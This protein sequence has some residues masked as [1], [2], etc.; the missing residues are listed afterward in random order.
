MSGRSTCQA[1]QSIREQGKTDRDALEIANNFSP[2]GILGRAGA[3]NKSDN[4]IINFLKNSITNTTRL[5]I[6]GKCKNATNS[7]QSNVY[8]GSDKC[9]IAMYQNCKNPITGITDL[10]CLDKVTK[11]L[12]DLRKSNVKVE[13]TNINT[14]RNLC[15][16]NSFIQAISSQ[17]TSL[18]NVAKLLSMQ[19][20]K[21]FLTNN[22]ADNLNCND[23]DVNVTNEQFISSVLNCLS[24]TSINQNNTIN[25][26][27][28]GARMS[29]QLNSN[30][31]FNN[32]LIDSG[33][34]VQNLQKASVVNDS[35]IENKQT[36]STFDIGSS[37]MIVIIV[38]VVIV[39]LFV[40]KSFSESK[41]TK[42]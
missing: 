14:S 18:S 32:C 31:M 5:N 22:K 39:A 30:S 2:G 3:S 37:I 1:I 13:Q 8:I 38:V 7:N 33:I 25:D 9:M 36:A 12:E 20:A 34:M 40:L 15:E 19:E 26:E 23:I 16:I 11:I 10:A 28:C 29:S 6:E 42:S 27:S 24:E 17:E 35:S 41:S 21:N 4:S